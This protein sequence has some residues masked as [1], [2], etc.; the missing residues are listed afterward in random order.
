MI[1][2]QVGQLRPDIARS[3]ELN[4]STIEEYMPTEIFPNTALLKSG[5]FS[6]AFAE[7]G[8]VDFRNAAAYVQQLPYGRNSGSPAYEY[9]LIDSSGTC[10]SKHAL[11][12]SLAEELSLDVALILGIYEMNEQNTP[13]VGKILEETGLHAIPEAHCWL[14][15]RGQDTDLTFA[16]AESFADKKIFLHTEVIKPEQSTEYKMEL[17]RSQ[18]RAWLRLHD[19]INITL[20][21][22]WSIR[23]KCIESL[24][25]QSP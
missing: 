17:H 7:Y 1:N 22:A 11:I 12:A 8:C 19:R 13:G 21:K 14:R 5:R 15:Y 16:E 23:E 4:Q 3:R 9:V 2:I 24:S 10:S 25:T 18:L 6:V 20:A